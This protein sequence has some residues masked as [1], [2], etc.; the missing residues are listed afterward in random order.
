MVLRIALLC[1]LALA[2]IGCKT[3]CA[4]AHDWTSDALEKSEDQ[5]LCE[6]TPAFWSF[7]WGLT[8]FDQDLSSGGGSGSP[9][10]E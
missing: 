4:G 2:S 1:G 5:Q 7:F 10:L 3:F 6:E 9:G 8:G